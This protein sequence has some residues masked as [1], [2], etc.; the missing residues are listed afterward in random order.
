MPHVK[1]FES[2]E[3]ELSDAALTN[4]NGGILN[5]HITAICKIY[6]QQGAMNYERINTV[7]GALSGATLEFYRLVAAPYEDKKRKENGD[8]WKL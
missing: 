5:A 7:I 3:E 6:L 4:M 1:D 8:A 2:I